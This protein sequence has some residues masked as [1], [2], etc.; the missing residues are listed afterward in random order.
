V[1]RVV[2]CGMGA[3]GTEILDY[4]LKRFH[5][6]VGVVD[7]DPEKVGRTVAELTSLPLGTRVTGSIKDLQ[8][9]GADVAIF[10]TR[11]RIPE[12]VDDIT[13]AVSNGL[14]VVTTSEEMAY[15][16]YSGGVAADAL[17]K[18]AME[19]GVTVVGVGVNPG[20]VMDL[21]P[22]M[23]ATAS[24]NPTSIHVVRSVDV[25]R[26][27]RQLQARTGVGHTRARFEKGLKDGAFGHVGL[28][29]SAHLIAASLGKPLE[30]LKHGIFPVLGSEDYVMG[31]RQFAEGKAGD[32]RIR[33]DLEMTTTS[34]DFD[35]VEVKG[36]PELKVRFEKGV[37]GD[38]ATVALAVHAAERVGRAKTGL[39]TVL[40]LPF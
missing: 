31:V 34:A 23:V 15:P 6:V 2:L 12:I 19:K 7:S 1:V 17:N 21:V 25:S 35:V 38:S 13:F 32:C 26:R 3:I 29:E 33:L 10:C 14:D 16:A 20:F 40:D 39:I 24:K 5:E 22:A 11:S 9:G 8:L 27:R 37:F 36:D 18:L 28:I 4:L 30:D